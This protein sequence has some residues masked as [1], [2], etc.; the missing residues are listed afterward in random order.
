MVNLAPET[1]TSTAACGHGVRPALTM[2]H[3]VV[4]AKAER[5]S[6]RPVARTGTVVP[7][8]GVSLAGPLLDGRAVLAL[9]DSSQS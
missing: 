8:S 6:T 5:A 9:N 2:R 3:D 1:A 7:G 4:D